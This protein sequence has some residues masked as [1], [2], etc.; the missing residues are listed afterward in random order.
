[1]SE[2]DGDEREPDGVTET[3]G[4]AET[5]GRLAPG[6]APPP[7]T[8]QK[9]SRKAFAREIATIVVIALALSF[10]V[11]TFVAQPYSIPSQSM[12]NTLLPGDRIIVSKFTPQHSPLHRG[13]V[14]VFTRPTSWGPNPAPE[15]SPVKRAV[16]DALVFI[17]VLPGGGE[18]LVKRLIGLPGD[19]VKCCTAKGLLSVNGTPIHE[20]YVKPGNVPSATPFDITVPKGRVWVMGDNRGNSADSRV[21]GDGRTG[22]VPM[23]DI[24]GQVVAIAWPLSRI[25]S[26]KSYPQTFAKVPEH[27]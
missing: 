15:P 24:S 12:E 4:A 11:K 19:H 14:I 6:E 7:R 8:P 2:R 18:H 27:P 10:L 22:S 9:K 3:D 5:D 13:D 21:H 1:M 23:S 17:G 25:Q 16:K 26:L 20:P